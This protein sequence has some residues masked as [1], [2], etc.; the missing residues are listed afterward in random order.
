MLLPTRRVQPQGQLPPRSPL[1]G[2]IV[3]GRNDRLSERSARLL[4]AGWWGG[5][6]VIVH[7]SLRRTTAGADNAADPASETHQGKCLLFRGGRS[8]ELKQRQRRVRAATSD[9]SRARWSCP[10]W[11][12]GW[13]L[14]VGV[15]QTIAIT[16]WDHVAQGFCP[17][18]LR[19]ERHTVSLPGLIGDQQTAGACRSPRAERRSSPASSRRT[20]QVLGSQAAALIAFWRDLQQWWSRT[21]YRSTCRCFKSYVRRRDADG[22]RHRPAAC[23]VN[24]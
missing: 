24:R 17:A 22:R 5:L 21:L 19:F 1:I 14:D 20:S 3:P 16:T 10:V 2:T 18:D 9:P 15:G 12:G 6:R 23:L 13:A 11:S 8:P 4:F 7:E